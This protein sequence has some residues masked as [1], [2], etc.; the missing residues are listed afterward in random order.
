MV[1]K[2]DEERK[3]TVEDME[4]FESAQDNM[5]NYMDSYSQYFNLPSLY[6]QN[7]LFYKPKPKNIIQIVQ[8]IYPDK[9]EEVKVFQHYLDGNSFMTEFDDIYD[10]HFGAYLKLVSVDHGELH[11]VAELPISSTS[12]KI[13]V[14]FSEDY[15][16]LAISYVE[17][18]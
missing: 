9:Q 3:F 17:K 2:L 10:G 15:S 8:Y 16:Q 14:A 11:T 12:K 7:Q 18:D 4:K 13:G 5:R 1:N 6:V